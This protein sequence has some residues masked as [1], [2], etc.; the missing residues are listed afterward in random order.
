MSR[1]SWVRIFKRWW[2]EDVCKGMVTRA[3][4]A[5]GVKLLDECGFEF[6]CSFVFSKWSFKKGGFWK[7]GVEDSLKAQSD[8][9]LCLMTLFI[10]RI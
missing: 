10:P 6:V 9:K 4:E 2:A 3:E 8:L 7:R 5:L 1:G